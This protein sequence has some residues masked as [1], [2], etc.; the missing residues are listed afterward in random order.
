MSDPTPI[1]SPAIPT[2]PNAA[3]LK[4][5]PDRLSPILVKELRQG[6]R[7]HGFTLLFIFLQ[8]IMG[9]V[10]FGSLVGATPGDQDGLRAGT[11]ITGFFFT[12][13]AIAAL[14]V[15]PLRGLNALAGEIKPGTIDL[16]L[17][18]RMDS[19]RITVGKWLAL[20]TQTCLL[21]I[22]ILP[23]LIMRYYLGGMQ[24]FNELLGL[25]TILVLSGALTAAAVGFSATTSVVLRGLFALGL[26]FCLFGFAAGGVASL[27][28]G[29]SMRG[30]PS[31]MDPSQSGFLLGYAAF[32]VVAIFIGYYFL[33]MGA[34]QIA[35]PSENRSTRKRLLGLLVV[36]L[37]LWVTPWDPEPKFIIAGFLV[38]LLLI[39]AITE[40]PEFTASV[41]KPFRR[42]GP[43]GRL[44]GAVLLPG[45]HHGALFVGILLAFFFASSFYHFSETSMSRDD[46]TGLMF[47]ALWFASLLLPAIG[48]ALFRKAHRNTFPLYCVVLIGCGIVSLLIT[49][50]AH[51][52]DVEEA[53]AWFFLVFPPLGIAG[54][55]E[56]DNN[57]VAGMF[58]ALL[59]L[60]CWWGVLV[61]LARSW[62]RRSNELFRQPEDGSPPAS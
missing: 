29:S 45:W 54:I 50:L 18:T 24:L 37:T 19:W 48:L 12:L 28:V 21:L 44:L 42:F 58:P 49:I 13:F 20:F 11:T 55:D 10:V 8:A 34:T 6:L 35:P 60:A 33:E 25:F 52:L 61:F 7:Q 5:F 41:W 17:L 51:A 16:L 2:A 26:A 9:I 30:G 1:S 47:I 4:D 46:R 36:A 22:A 23:Y 38:F 40:N 32:I 14:G 56:L 3:L 15:Q 27:I 43:L 57:D 39:D 62:F 53:V 59:V 31:F